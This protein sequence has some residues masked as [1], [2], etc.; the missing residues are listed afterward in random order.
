MRIVNQDHSFQ[1]L[2]T[3]ILL[4]ASCCFC[5]SIGNQG[6]HVAAVRSTHTMMMSPLAASLGQVRNRLHARECSIKGMNQSREFQHLAEFQR[7]MITQEYFDK[8]ER[9]SGKDYRWI[10]P[11]DKAP[12]SRALKYVQYCYFVGNCRFH[13]TRH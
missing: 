12:V 8:L 1:C 4:K 13:L 9:A 6:Q 3:L 5:Y 11:L 7:G 10:R 2:A